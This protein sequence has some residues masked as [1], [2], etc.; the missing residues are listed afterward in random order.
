MK[1]DVEYD[2]CSVRCKIVQDWIVVSKMIEKGLLIVY[3]GV[4]KGK[5]IVVFGM[6]VWMMG[7][8]CKVGVVQFVKGVM[9]IG[10]KVIFD[11][12]LDLVEFKLMGEG[13][14][15]DMQDCVC[16]IVVV[17]EVWDEVKWMI[18]DL[19]YVMVL[20]DEINIVL[21]YDYLLF[22]EVLVVFVVK[23]EMMYVVVIGCNVLDVLIEM[24][25]FV[26]EMMQV[27]YLF[28]VGVKVQVGIEFQWCVLSWCIRFLV[29]RMQ[30]GLLQIVYVCGMWSCWMWLRIG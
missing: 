30:V 7:Y 24:V 14:I 21:C 27:K 1:I 22:D 10:E 26:I 2:V 9:L 16:D 25:D 29:V 4:G 11:V 12:F 28:C 18:V 23:F 6:V 15:W 20:V 5:I 13:F 8:G 17:C 19:F 3:I